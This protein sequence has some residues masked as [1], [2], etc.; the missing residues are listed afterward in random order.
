VQSINRNGILAVTATDTSAL[1]GTYPAAT[2]RKYWA[3]PS[4]TWAMHEVGIRILTRKVQLIAAQYEKA[5]VPLISIVT[6]HYY[7]IFF[8]CESSHTAVKTVLAQHKFLH[9]C[10]CLQIT[11]S[12]DSIGECSNC[13]EKVKGVG[14]LW[15]GKI[16]NLDF[17]KRMRENLGKLDEKTAKGLDKKLAI[18]EDEACSDVVGFVD[19]HELASR[20]NIQAPR[21]ETILE[22]T[23]ARRTH[24]NG[25]GIKTE[26]KI[27]ELLKI[28]SHTHHDAP[29]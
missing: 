8:R 27:A 6:D 17:V 15:T 9:I 11:P 21:T 3:T 18:I 20:Y 25:A 19:I 10:K 12:V 7:R 22:K 28:N 14:L 23:K 16:H 2:A 29:Q 1:A 4:R 13:G 24:I 5:L 26:L